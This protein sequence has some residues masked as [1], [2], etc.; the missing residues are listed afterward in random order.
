M[1]PFPRLAGGMGLSWLCVLSRALAY[2]LFPGDGS[3]EPGFVPPQMGKP[4]P[5]PP[6]HVASGESYIPYPGPPVTPQARSEKKKP[7]SPPVLFTKLTSRYGPLDWGTRPNDLNNLLKSMKQMID[8][9]FSAEVKS[10]ADVDA[11]PDKN[12]ILYRSGHFHFEFTPEERRKIRAFLLA[13]GMLV[14]NAGMGSKPFYDSALRELALIFPEVPVRRL[15]SDHPIF[16]AYYSLS[17]VEYRSGVRKAGYLESEP[18]L[19]GVTLHCRTVAVVSR[20]GLDIGWDATDDDSM[21]GYTIDSAQR[22]GV[23]LMAYAI[24]QRA[25]AKNTARAIELADAEPVSVGR[26]RIAQIIYDGEWKTRHA[27]LSVLLHQ[28]NQKT[29]IPVRFERVELRLTD[30]RLF[31]APLLFMTGH[32]DFRLSD[33][34]IAALRRYL[35]QGGF[36]LAEACCGRRAFDLAFRRELARALAG[37]SLRPV[38]PGSPVLT[39]PNPITVLGVTPALAAHL[40]NRSTMPPQLFSVEMDGHTAVIYS[41]FGMA[42]GWELSQNPY[43]LGY[44]DTSALLLGENLLMYALM[45]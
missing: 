41:P 29:D 34:E 26:M 3:D 30:P 14:L 31:D 12:P 42:G 38:Q 37:S 24:A 4:P 11:D 25:W 17:R 43:A 7:P 27:G 6:A 15:G 40:Q 10:L 16:Q 2:I 1:K 44:D 35:I 21:L 13:G 23:N 39:L 9:N 5:P 18:W 33:E 20:W 28:F 19:D 36:L 32:E 8:V 22:L 45:Q